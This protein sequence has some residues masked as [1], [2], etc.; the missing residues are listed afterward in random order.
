MNKKVPALWIGGD[1]FKKTQRNNSSCMKIR[2]MT[3]ER[4][5]KESDRKVSQDVQE[6][7]SVLLCLDSAHNLISMLL[8]DNNTYQTLLVFSAL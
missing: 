6:G 3:R 7:L 8:F 2:A 1:N 4:Q 5:T